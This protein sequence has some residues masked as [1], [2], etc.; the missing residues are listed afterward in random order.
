MDKKSEELHPQSWDAEEQVPRSTKPAPDFDNNDT[1]STSKVDARFWYPVHIVRIKTFHPKSGSG[2]W[3]LAL[4]F[5]IADVDYQE[6]RGYSGHTQ[7]INF[8]L[9]IRSYVQV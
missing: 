1:A 7:W 3:C 6:T 8:A 4:C 9:T 5:K 2:N